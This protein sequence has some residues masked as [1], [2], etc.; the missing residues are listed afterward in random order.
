MKRIMVIGCPGSGKSTFSRA[1]RDRLG[2]PLIYMDRLF[3]NADRTHVDRDEMNRRVENAVSGSEWIIDG[4]YQRTL[5]MR[6]KACDKVFLLDIPRDECIKGITRR[7]GTA[8]EDM[9][10]V[11]TGMDEELLDYVRRFPDEQLRQIYE[12]LESY[13]D[14]DITV[15]K[16]RHEADEYLKSI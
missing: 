2:L 7:I 4:N 13:A 12:L 6:V 5:E 15:F 1:L 11:E 10:W 14:K 9:P 8:R 3:W 16:S